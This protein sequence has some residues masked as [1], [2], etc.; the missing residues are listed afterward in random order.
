M[1][2]PQRRPQSKPSTGLGQVTEDSTLTFSVYHDIQRSTLQVHLSKASNLP[3]QKSG[4]KVF[5]VTQLDPNH[6]EIYESK[7]VD[8]VANPQFDEVYEFDNLIYCRGNVVFQVYEGY[9]LSKGNFIGS[10]VLPLGE[11]DLF[12]AITTM[13]IDK[14]GENLPVSVYEEVDDFVG[15][16]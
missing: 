2:Q 6:W 12:G 15:P 7:P 11:A 14:S 3:V 5:V 1:E 8:F 4:K 16:L 13:K 10:V 9:K